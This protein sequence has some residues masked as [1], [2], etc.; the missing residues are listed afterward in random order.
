VLDDRPRAPS[1]MRFGDFSAPTLENRYILLPDLCSS[2]LFYRLHVS[3]PQSVT[4][5]PRAANINTCAAHKNELP[6]L[7]R[8]ASSSPKTEKRQK[9]FNNIEMMQKYGKSQVEALT[10]ASST[11]TKG[12]QQIAEEAAGFSKKHFETSSAALQ[13]LFGAK[14]VEKAIEIQTRFAKTSFESLVAQSTKVGELYT[15][16]VT[17]ALKPAEQ[18][19]AKT[20]AAASTTPAVVS[21]MKAAA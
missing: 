1:N 7:L 9:M 13:E 2:G 19:F 3:H 18:I 4:F 8:L 20:D 17:E 11:F 5:M 12:L 10:T 6:V 21:K 16:L 14:T 15:S